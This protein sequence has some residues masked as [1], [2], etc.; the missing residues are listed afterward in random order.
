MPDGRH[1]EAGKRRAGDDGRAS[2]HR[3]PLLH[4]GLPLRL[5]QLQLERPAAFPAYHRSGVSHAHQGRGGKVHV[6]RRASGARRATGVR[7]SVPA[8]GHDFRRR[9]GPVLHGRA[10]S[11][12]ATRVPPQARA[13]GRAATMSG[14]RAYRW[15]MAALAAAIVAGVLLWVR[16]WNQGLALTGMSRDVAWGLYVGQ[17][18]FFVGVAASAVTVVLPYYLHAWK[19]FGRVVI[20]GELLAIA[21][22]VVSLLFIIVD[23]G[24][25]DR[26]LNM[27]LYP[28]PWSPMFWGMLALTGYLALNGMAAR[29]VLAA[30]VG[31]APPATWTRAIMLISIP[32]AVSIHTVTAFLYAGLAGRPFWLTAAMAPRFL[33]SA[34]AAGPALLILLCGA[35]RYDAGEEAL[36]KLRLVMT[37]AMTANVFLALMEVFTAFYSGI[38]EHAAHYSQW[39]WLSGG[40][41]LAALGMALESHVH[42]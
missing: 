39:T 19:A 13:G 5:P 3:L 21:S 32:W 31:G 23:M 6:L 30:E 41:A 34:F 35:F 16:Q 38:P 22:I 26:L 17:F 20:L 2:L 12:R 4:G 36:R 9:G 37:Y 25:P 14:S 28:S 15:W 29:A 27:L 40:L 1:L 42:W 7:R 8:Q 11:P 33:A 10:A 24:R 18:T